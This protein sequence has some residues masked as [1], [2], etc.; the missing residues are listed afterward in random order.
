MPQDFDEFA[1]FET[2]YVARQRKAIELLHQAARQYE[3]AGMHV[4]ALEL[5]CVIAK[6]DASMEKQLKAFMEARKRI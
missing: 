1:P 3:L 2:I 4:E 6:R 5:D